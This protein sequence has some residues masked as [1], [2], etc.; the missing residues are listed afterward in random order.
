VF[1]VAAQVLIVLGFL[2]QAGAIGGGPP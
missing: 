1:Y 2:A